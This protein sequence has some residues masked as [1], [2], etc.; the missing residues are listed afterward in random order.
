MCG[1]NGILSGSLDLQKRIQAMNDAMVHRGP[2]AE[3][4]FVHE[5]IAF[6]HRRLSILDLDP[7][8]NQPFYSPDGRYIM[9]FNGEI[10]NYQELKKSLPDVQWKTASDTEVL[11]HAWIQWGEKCLIH[12]NGMFA[13]AVWDTV[14]NELFIARDRMGIKPLYYFDGHEHFVFSSEVRS[15]LASGFVD[16]KLNASAL[17]D[18]LMYLTVHAPDTIVENVKMLLPGHWMKLSDGNLTMEQWWNP[19]VDL[20]T[21]NPKRE[22]AVAQVRKLLEAAV[23]RRLVSDVPF[24]AFLSGGIDSSAVVALMAQQMNRPVDTFHIAFDESEF[25]E[26][27]YAK[28][29]ADKFGTNHHKI[30]IRPS[31]FLE[32]LPQALDAVDHPGA[33]GPNTWI[34]SKA[35]RDAGVKMVLSGLGGDE[36]FGGYDVFKQLPKLKSK[37][38]VMSFPRFMRS[39]AGSML[40]KARPSVSSKK[41]AAILMQD[42][43]YMEYT[44]R[45]SRMAILDKDVQKLLAGNPAFT[46]RVFDIMKNLT[47]VGAPAARFEQFTQISFAEMSTYLPNVLLRDT[48]QMSMAHALEVRVPMLDFQLVEYMLSLP[49]SLKQSVLS[50]KQLLVEAMGDDLPTELVNRQKMG[51]TFPW[52]N[53]LKNELRPLTETYIHA[54]S[55]RPEMNET[56]V[57]RLWNEFLNDHPT[58][59]WAVIW[60][61]VVLEHYLQK[62]GIS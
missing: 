2:D 11:L 48:D 51:F 36:F 52:K 24:G 40:M 4:T 43:W 10:Y 37:G 38:W 5:G 32:T 45:F 3:G 39:A 13:F 33:D 25:S 46:N 31:E 57:L 7:R 26:A 55:K 56:A 1:I 9:V 59:R 54:F 49:A 23:S 35:A 29:M 62:H 20:N 28:M 6:G 18:Y 41:T 47:G 53:W 15:L 19:A 16:K 30:V 42:A 12:L 17:P 22:E 50:P 60:N 34:V 61:I 58:S 14:S 8:S 21:R 27:R 44:Y